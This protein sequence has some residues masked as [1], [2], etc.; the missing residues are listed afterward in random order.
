MRNR[1]SQP[2]P[3]DL[4]PAN[5]SPIRIYGQLVGPMRQPENGVKILLRSITTNQE[6]LQ[7]TWSETT[8]DTSGN[9][10]FQVMP[11]KYAVFFE[12]R[13]Q[14]ARV[15]NIYVYSDSEPGNLQSFFLAPTPDQLTP[16]MVMEV[17]GGY[18][19]TTA[20]MYRARQWAENPID[21]PVLDFEQGAGPEFSAY[22][23][24][25]YAK[26]ML[27]TDTNINWRGEWNSTTAYAFR[28]GVRWRP[29][30]STAYSSYY[31]EEDNTGI[32]PPDVATGD[33]AVWSLMAAGGDKGQGGEASTVPGPPNTLTIGEV[34]AVP[35]GT[36]PGASF[37]GVSPN[38]VLNLVLETGPKGDST[39]PD[40]SNYYTKT[41]V[42]GLVGERIMDI[43]QGTK[44]QMSTGGPAWDYDIAGAYV[45]GSHGDSNDNDIDALNYRPLMKTYDGVSW[46]V[47]ARQP[48]VG[49]ASRNVMAIQSGEEITRL[50]NL[51]PYTPADPI[52]DTIYLIDESGR[53]W[54]DSQQYFTGSFFIA[55]D[56]VTGAI[57]QIDSVI[58]ALWP[59]GL[60]VASLD[61]I[62]E[63]CDIYGEWYYSDGVIMHVTPSVE[64]V[65][66]GVRDKFLNKSDS[67]VIQDY[68]INDEYL[69][70]DQRNE[71]FSTR[72][73]FKKWPS[74]T[75]WP[76]ISLPTVPE[77][78]LTELQT[79]NYTLPAWPL[80]E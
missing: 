80:S 4:P 65:A 42:I 28:D 75:G 46:Y 1:L 74:Q 68:T 64:M 11:G 8:T 29:D 41:D 27:D 23:W 2:R 51:Q 32:S 35:Y 38:Q 31:C 43:S 13:G 72:L 58:W 21:V 26:E 47:I 76:D 45:T 69:T 63:G 44:G 33:N 17:K 3:L 54:H 30:E 19:E 62:P 48:G 67:L 61:D 24:A 56:P 66:R 10:D 5:I 60:S 52:I 20:A 18:E 79:K 57:K 16:L 59:I 39:P 73:N 9:Y 12:R 78:I 22:H 71:L 25:H 36:P 77:W 55:Y 34:T 53:D 50:I 14:K 37:S 7:D 49:L 70:T 15:N 6:I 40:M